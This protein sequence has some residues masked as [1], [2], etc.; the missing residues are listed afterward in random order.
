MPAD[1]IRAWAGFVNGRL[2]FYPYDP[3]GHIDVVADLFRTRRAA[4]AHY[5][6]VRRVTVTAERPIRARA[7]R[8]RQA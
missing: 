2:H 4:Q 3:K 5:E 6:D 8:R 7:A 1:R